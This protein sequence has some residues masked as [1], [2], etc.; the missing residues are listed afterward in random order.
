MKSVGILKKKLVIS[1]S[2]PNKVKGN[3]ISVMLQFYLIFGSQNCY[4]IPEEIFKKLLNITIYVYEN[5]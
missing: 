2:I 1:S 5:S 4:W 3:K